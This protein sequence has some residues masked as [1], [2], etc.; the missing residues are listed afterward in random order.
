MLPPIGYESNMRSYLS[1]LLMLFAS[2]CAAVMDSQTPYYQ[3]SPNQA[4][5]YRT[6]QA[7]GPPPAPR[8]HVQGMLGATHLVI[9]DIDIDSNF[10]SVK[11]SENVELPVIG[12]AWQQAFAGERAVHFGLEGGFTLGW[13]N[14]I[15]AFALGSNGA[16]VVA[17]NDVLLTDLFIGAY[18]DI[19]LGQK[20][21]LYAGIGPTLQFASVDYE[22]D[23]PVFGHVH[24]NDDGFGTGYYSRIGIELMMRPGMALGFGFRY[25]DSS[26][27]FG[28]KI[29]SMDFE[30]EQY[31][32]TFTESY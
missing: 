27:D 29:D 6:L 4:A 2:S 30:Q 18:G 11:D 22:Y 23:D 20:V 7:S 21:R 5:P 25:I 14:D 26:V 3:S 16:A 13:E 1:V 28:G 10:G 32:L 15:Q 9:T 8:S 17:D 24:V 12:G 31:V 19:N